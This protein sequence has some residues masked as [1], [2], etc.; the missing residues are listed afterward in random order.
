[1][2]HAVKDRRIQTEWNIAK[3]MMSRCNENMRMKEMALM[4]Q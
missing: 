2:I 1:M 3:P 4:I